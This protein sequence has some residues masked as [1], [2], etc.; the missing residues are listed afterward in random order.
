MCFFPCEIIYKSNSCLDLV[1]NEA[2][3]ELWGPLNVPEIESSILFF[4][5]KISG[6][7]SI[8]LNQARHQKTCRNLLIPTASRVYP[9][10]PKNQRKWKLPN[11]NKLTAIDNVEIKTTIDIDCFVF[12][13]GNFKRVTPV[14]TDNY[15]RAMTKDRQGFDRGIYRTTA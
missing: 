9:F 4:D 10:F 3:G 1:T 14:I 6:S 13:P 2:F 7:Y 11:Q 15:Q 12:I 5:V 8:M